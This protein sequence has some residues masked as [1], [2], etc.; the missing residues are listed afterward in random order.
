MD[1]YMVILFAG[2]IGAASVICLGASL[3]N[4]RGHERT[5]VVIMAAGL[6]ALIGWFYV[7]GTAF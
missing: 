7:M 4:D 2:F 3:A 6:T 5:G 1:A